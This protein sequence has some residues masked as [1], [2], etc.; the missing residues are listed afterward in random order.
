MELR[1]RVVGETGRL[2]LP[3][4]NGRALNMDDLVG[5]YPFFLKPYQPC[6]DWRE[7]DTIKVCDHFDFYEALRQ[8]VERSY[9]NCVVIVGV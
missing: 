7:S 2:V 9:D 3:E 1:I 8:G 4:C 6:D 5:H